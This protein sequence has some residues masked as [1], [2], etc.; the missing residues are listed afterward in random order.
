VNAS[1]LSGG[2]IDVEQ[3]AKW[4]MPTRVLHL[5]IAL[6]IIALF[7]SAAGVHLFGDIIGKVAEIKI[8]YIHLYLGLA[9]TA[10]VGARI[11]W[12]FFGNDSVNWRGIPS[13]IAKYPGWASAEIGY[14]FRGIDSG[15]RKKGGHNALA[16][17]VYFLA[18]IMILLQFATGLGM[19]DGLDKK[20]KK[21]GVVQAAPMAS[22]AAFSNPMD[23]LVPTA[24]AH[25]GHAAKGGAAMG[26]EPVGEKKEE[27]SLGEEVHEFG[28]FWV[29]IFLAMHLGGIFIHYRRG[30]RDLLEGMKIAG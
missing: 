28:L 17:P 13:G 11:L 24:S 18:L 7:T 22:T 26:D 10:S 19:R 16:I 12:G 21:H 1:K 27:E 3:K 4:D 14:V 30:E 8:K 5:I 6:L 25:E 2:F 15:K 23:M 20:A 29:P 9:L